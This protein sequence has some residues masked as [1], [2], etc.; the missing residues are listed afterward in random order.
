VLIIPGPLLGDISKPPPLSVPE[1]EH[2]LDTLHASTAAGVEIPASEFAAARDALTAA[3]GV[4]RQRSQA[5]AGTI[6][7]I[8]QYAEAEA[9][10]RMTVAPR[11]PILTEEEAMTEAQAHAPTAEEQVAQC[12]ADTEETFRLAKVFNA[13]HLRGDDSAAAEAHVAFEAHVVRTRKPVED[14]TVTIEA[15]TTGIEEAAEQSEMPKTEEQKFWDFHRAFGG[16]RFLTPELLRDLATVRRLDRDA[17][18]KQASDTLTSDD[19]EAR[20][21]RFTDQRSDWQRAIREHPPAPEQAYEAET[22][23]QAAN[24]VVDPFF[25]NVGEPP[26]EVTLPGGG[27]FKIPAGLPPLLNVEQLGEAYARADRRAIIEP[28]EPIMGVVVTCQSSVGTHMGVNT[29]RVTKKKHLII[30]GPHAEKIA[31]YP[32]GSWR[33]VTKYHDTSRAERS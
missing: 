30:L 22:Q 4:A 16:P 31:R 27:L 29:W 20:A 2:W 1:A 17:Q 18:A 19:T 14:V 12:Q 7:T 26:G 21:P 9:V 15:D 11:G 28:S 10:R 24:K 3:L 25:Q 8:N 13:A 5:R 23:R 6:G 33:T 32:A